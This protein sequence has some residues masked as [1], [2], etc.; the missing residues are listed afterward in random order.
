MC[1]KSPILL[2]HMWVGIRILCLFHLNIQ[3]ISIM[4]LNCPKNAIYCLRG[5]TIFSDH[6]SHS[7]TVI[8]ILLHLKCKQ[9]SAE[10]Y[11]SIPIH[12][13]EHHTKYNIHGAVRHPVR[14]K[15]RD[16]S[17]I[18][19]LENWTLQIQLNFCLKRS[20]TFSKVKSK[21]LWQWDLKIG[22]RLCVIYRGR[23]AK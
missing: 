23:E 18:S 7:I 20:S 12:S 22:I 11:T 13:K 5:H 10:P 4:N 14:R 1:S 21:I 19:L 6:V 9:L 3:T 16:G 8:F 15:A 17:S 2:F